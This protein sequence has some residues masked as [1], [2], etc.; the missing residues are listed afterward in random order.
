MDNKDKI[1]TSKQRHSL[2]LIG[3][4]FSSLMLNAQTGNEKTSSLLNEA[5][6]I[7]TIILILIP[8]FAGIVFMLFKIRIVLKKYRNKQNLEDAD[9]L[10]D[11]ISG[12]SDEKLIGVLQK[13][14]AALDYQ[15][16][17]SELSGQS[18]TTLMKKGIINNAGTASGLTFVALKRKQ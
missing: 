17:N 10:V 5:G 13:R 11:Y 1:D 9:K 3:A 6:I 4:L 15:L 7:I 16:S 12:L 18:L 14:K 8:I 2:F